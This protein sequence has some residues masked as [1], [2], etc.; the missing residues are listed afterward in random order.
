MRLI[1]DWM[2]DLWESGQFTGTDYP[3][4]RATISKNVLKTNGDFRE[5]LFEQDAIAYEI[6]NI[7]QVTIDRNLS[8]DAAQL[9]LKIRNQGGIDVAANLD[10]T[11]DGTGSGPTKRE[12]RDLGSPGYFTFRRGLAVD[13]SGINPWAHDVNTW[14]DMFIPNRLIRVY[15]GYG[16]DGSG[17]PALDA[18]LVLTGT[19]LID[20][21]DY[22]ASGDITI[23]G[24]DL[25]KL[26]LEQRLYPPIIPVE[27]YPLEFCADYVETQSGTT[28]NTTTTT[29]T[30]EGAQGDNV[31]VH[32]ATNPDSS[33]AVWYGYNASVYGHTATHA[34]DGNE[35]SYWLS[36]G[37]SGP[38]EVWSYEWI[39]ADCGGEPITHIRFKPKWGG[40]TCYVAV[41][42][43]GVWQGTS[44][45]PYGASSGPAYPNGSNIPYL[46]KITIPSSENWI[47]IDLGA[48]YQADQIR[49]IFTNLAYSGLGTYPYRAAVYELQAYSYTPP[50][51]ETV[52][53]TE[54]VETQVDVLVPGN[55][56]DYTDIIKIF[57]AWSGFYWPYGDPDPTLA[58]WLEQS[59][60]S[61][62]NVAG[63]TLTSGRVWGDFFYSG[64]YPVEP[65]C[66]DPSYWDNKSVMDGINQIKEILGF[67]FFGDPYGGVVWRP[68]N[69]WKTGNYVLGQGYVGQDSIHTVSEDNVLINYGVTIDDRNLRSDIIV[70][71]ADDPSVYG[72]YQPGFALGE[73]AP[74]ATD[75]SDLA[76]LGGQQRV[77]LVPNY[78][79][80]SG[81]SER[82]RLEVE[83]FAFL[84][85][86][87]IHWSY[88]RSKFRVPGNPAFMPDDQVRIYE[89]TTSETYIHY[90]QSVRSTMDLEQGTWY[91]DMD[92]HWLGNGPDAEWVVRANEMHPALFVYL[93]EI[94]QI[95]DDVEADP[96]L[97]P[98]GWETMPPITIPEDPPRLDTDLDS[99]FPDPPTIVWPT[100]EFDTET[101]DTYDQG[102][103]TPPDS[104][105]SGGSAYACSNAAKFKYWGPGPSTPQPTST[106]NCD[107]SDLGW[108]TFMVP[109]IAAYGSF[110]PE[111]V[112]WNTFNGQTDK[113]TLRIDRRAWPAYKLLIEIMVD[114]EYAL[115]VS[116]CSSY[117]CRPVKLLSGG[118]S[119]S[120]WSNHAWGLAV[121]FNSVDNKYGVRLGA[122]ADLYPV[123]VRAE[124]EI[125]CNNGQKVFRWGNW[126]STNPDPMHFEVCCTPAD[127][128]SGVHR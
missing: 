120:T 45:V 126:Y 28:T 52:T 88:R 42:V 80:G 57:C 19:F 18:R 43:N 53:N 81:D 55:I 14:V 82:A 10:E 58:R 23:T 5:L 68:P 127:L 91:L 66:I 62:P 111:D 121:D 35:S 110:P 108:Y 72:A 95:P 75:T 78:P 100:P 64:A 3:N 107:T 4:T 102:W 83:K 92:T 96:T 11:H 93:R 94:G 112:P 109:W 27:D 114:E 117:N 13:S 33:S 22:T 38:T 9:T 30:T 32:I 50:S 36:V 98:P 6:P 37:N 73:T 101:G 8:A 128:A 25:V 86:L 74:S 113:I 29:I 67:I 56:T 77:M 39:G 123:G 63:S 16:T 97:F 46:Q 61:D 84:T 103:I 12:L 69:I 59:T 87:W 2:W 70:V 26:L 24:R 40:Y 89:R 21:V 119:T 60:S 115:D 7:A 118:Y 44:I 79:F 124:S 85:S 122:A 20:K 17:D 116:Q 49:L 15:Q 71:S 90:L 65:P 41:K 34:F 31:A 51:T 47:E 54:T 104:S 105:G 125:R 76:L 106:W 1:P 99:L 48:T